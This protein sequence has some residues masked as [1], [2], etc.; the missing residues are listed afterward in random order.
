MGFAGDPATLCAMAAVALALATL[1]LL[2]AYLCE[3]LRTSL[4]QTR[5]LLLLV[6]FA[7]M[8]VAIVRASPQPWVD[9]WTV[10]QGAAEALRHGANPYS[11]SYPN[12]YA[13]LSGRMYAP[14][15]LVEGRLAAFP[16]PPLTV[17]GDLPAYLLLDKL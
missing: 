5:F 1:L 2:S 14:E 4:I 9:V 8:G 13:S 10:Q 16:Y 17:L 6:C 7:L 11:V 3:H 12:I 15:L